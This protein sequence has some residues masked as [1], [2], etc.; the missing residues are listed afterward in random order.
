MCRW[1]IFILHTKALPRAMW[2]CFLQHQKRTQISASA[3][4][5]PV[6]EQQLGIAAGAY[7]RKTYKWR[8][9]LRFAKAVMRWV[10]TSHMRLTG[11]FQKMMRWRAN[12]CCGIRQHLHQRI[13]QTVCF[14]KRKTENIRQPECDKPI[15][16]LIGSTINSGTQSDRNNSELAYFTF[17]NIEETGIVEHC[18]TTFSCI[19]RHSCTIF[20]CF[21]AP[22]PLP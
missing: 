3:P 11:L 18:F 1:I 20:C 14:T 8:L 10:G 19:H 5:C 7:V 9:R 22:Q 2:S 12:I 13:L 17:A 4:A 15:E 21:D 16:W 6:T